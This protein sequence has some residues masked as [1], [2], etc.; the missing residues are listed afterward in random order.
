M[1]GRACR[2]SCPTSPKPPVE[3]RPSCCLNTLSVTVLTTGGLIICTLETLS[4]D[5]GD[6]CRLVVTDREHDTWATVASTD[7][8]GRWSGVIHFNEPPRNARR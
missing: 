1:H 2:M 5:F 7:V 3:A 8:R 4:A 6:L